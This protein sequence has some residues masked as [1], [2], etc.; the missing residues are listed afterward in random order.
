M[1]RTSRKWL[2]IGLTLCLVLFAVALPVSSFQRYRSSK[3]D[4]IIWDNQHENHASLSREQFTDYLEKCGAS[5]IDT[6][7]SKWTVRYDG[8]FR[9]RAWTFSFVQPPKDSSR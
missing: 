1:S 9:H 2:L 7:G 6:S 4:F 3:I 8:F 5:S